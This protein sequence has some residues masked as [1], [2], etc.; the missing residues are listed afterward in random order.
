MDE[1]VLVSPLPPDEC[2]SRLRAA[3]DRDG[4]RSL[5]GSRPVVGRVAHGL[6]RLR[7]RIG[8]RN[9]FQAVLAGSLKPCGAGTVFRGTAGL[10]P[11]VL[12]F[13]GVW[14]G[15]VA[16]AAIAGLGACLVQPAALAVPLLMAAFGG[17]LVGFGRWLAEGEAAFLVAFVAEVIAGQPDAGPAAAASGRPLSGD[18]NLGAMQPRQWPHSGSR[19]GRSRQ[20]NGPPNQALQWTRP[21]RRAAELHRSAAEGFRWLR[22]GRDWCSDSL[23]ES[24]WST[25]S[26]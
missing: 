25:P 21:K 17:G 8:Y 16:L 26:W 3:T 13:L 20:P 19:P 1:I 2:E 24:R 15:L 11:L 23:S 6:L 9:S 22:R 5:F 14:C 4:L 7:K 18:P 12:G 10:H